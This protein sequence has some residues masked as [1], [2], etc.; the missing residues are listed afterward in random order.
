MLPATRWRICDVP[1]RC[2]PGLVGSFPSR[3][4]RG[5]R[6]CACRRAIERTRVPGRTAVPARAAPV[7]WPVECLLVDNVALHDGHL[8]AA[9]CKD[10]PNG[11]RIDDQRCAAAE[12]LSATHSMRHCCSNAWFMSRTSPLPWL[13]L[14]GSTGSNTGAAGN[15]HRTAAFGDGSWPAAPMLRITDRTCDAPW[16]QPECG[17]VYADDRR[18]F[19]S[20]TVLR[21]LNAVANTRSGQA[22]ALDQARD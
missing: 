12:S 22:R 2:R 4:D 18:L 1:R 17:P 19:T 3:C 20:A 6:Q 16:R 10:C 8:P 7:R 21:A 14:P 13:V 11:R 15:A 5:C 9:A